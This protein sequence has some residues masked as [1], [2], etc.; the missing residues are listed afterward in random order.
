MPQPIPSN[1]IR[2]LQ[3]GEL[4]QIVPEWQ[5]PG[6]EEFACVVIEA[7]ADSPR[8]LIRTL[9]PDMTIQ[10]TETIEASKL[11][12]VIDFGDL[13]DM[14]PET[15]I[16]QHGGELMREQRLFFIE[17]FPAITLGTLGDKVTPEEVELCAQLHPS[18]ALSLAADHITEERLDQLTE[19][20]SFVILLHASHRL[21]PDALRR[22]AAI[23]PGECI[24][25]LEKHPES[26]LRQSLRPLQE[27]INP[28]VATV[29]ATMLKPGG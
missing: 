9:I 7:P 26:R 25:I 24:V 18:I 4:V 29:L 15:V 28:N 1:S 8:V 16:R 27:T 17:K 10:P 2:P 23:H 3:V 5:D 12:R 14:A 21:T 11:V 22:L 20:H 19:S 6:D 13:A